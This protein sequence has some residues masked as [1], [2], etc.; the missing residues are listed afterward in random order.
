[1]AY[2]SRALQLKAKYDGLE[3]SEAK[4]LRALYQSALMLTQIWDSQAVESLILC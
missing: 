1:M 2:R 4:R 3:V